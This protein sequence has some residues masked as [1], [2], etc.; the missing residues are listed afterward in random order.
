MC[1]GFLKNMGSKAGSSKEQKLQQKQK[2]RRL[3]LTEANLPIDEMID[4]KNTVLA[5][6]K[7]LQDFGRI[8]FNASCMHKLIL[9]TI[10]LCYKLLIKYF[11]YSL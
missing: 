5:F 6:K 10:V 9:I 1:S 7:S 3:N 8:V 11:L 2:F 4:I